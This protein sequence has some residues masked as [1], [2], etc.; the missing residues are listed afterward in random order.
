MKKKTRIRLE[1][2]KQIGITVARENPLVDNVLNVKEYYE[3]TYKAVKGKKP[4]TLRQFLSLGERLDREE[5]RKER[6][7]DRRVE[8]N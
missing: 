6:A 5:K 7:F 4:P 2:V 3:G 8:R 1:G